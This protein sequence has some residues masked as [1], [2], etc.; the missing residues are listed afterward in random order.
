M[1]FESSGELDDE[2]KKERARQREGEDAARASSPRLHRPTSDADP[3][4]YPLTRITIEIQA[5]RAASIETMLGEVDE[6]ADRLRS[7]ETAFA[8]EA[9]FGYRVTADQADADMFAPIA[10]DPAQIEHPQS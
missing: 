3:E 6:I 5:P 4:H 2:L 1:I 9:L 10:A 7:G 8:A